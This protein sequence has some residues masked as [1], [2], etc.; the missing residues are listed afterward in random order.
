MQLFGDHSYTKVNKKKLLV[1]PHVTVD[2]R[3]YFVY[4]IVFMY[5]LLGLKVCI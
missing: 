4:I 1:Q 2:F 3:W 5:L